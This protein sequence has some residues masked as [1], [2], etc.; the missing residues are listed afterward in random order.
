MPSFKEISFPEP[1]LVKRVAGN[2]QECFLPALAF[3]I[4]ATLPGAE[5]SCHRYTYFGDIKT[6]L[7]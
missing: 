1:L 2:D 5:G 7:L 4:A 6:G 3:M